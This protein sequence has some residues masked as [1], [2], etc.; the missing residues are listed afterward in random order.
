MAEGK[1]HTYLYGQVVKLEDSLRF[2]L[3]LSFSLPS[4]ELQTVGRVGNFETSVGF[5]VELSCGLTY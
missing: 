5:L 2:D 4:V 1:S 3:F